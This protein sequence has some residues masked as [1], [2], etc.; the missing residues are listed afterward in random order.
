MTNSKSNSNRQVGYL[1]MWGVMNVVGF[2]GGNV[3]SPDI[4]V[5]QRQWP[6]CEHR[7]AVQCSV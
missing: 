5:P 7:G 1:E 4:S 3:T 6:V 2:S